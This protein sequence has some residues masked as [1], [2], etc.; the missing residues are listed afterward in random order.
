MTRGRSVLLLLV[1]AG[2][3][4]F[5]STRELVMLTPAGSTG[6]VGVANGEP[7]ASE[8]GGSPVLAAQAAAFAVTALLLAMLGTLGRRI[9]GILMVLLGFGYAGA[10]LGIALGQDATPWAWTAVV[11]GL[12]A[13]AAA[14][15]VGFGRDQWRTSQKFERA[16]TAEGEAHP[17]D[18]PAA[19]WDALSRGEDPDDIR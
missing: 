7:A 4:W 8:G 19:A 6:P 2:I 17:D 3:L 9:T 10:S 1:I 5:I 15:F 16:G 18:D 14:G 11:A 13:A 12:A